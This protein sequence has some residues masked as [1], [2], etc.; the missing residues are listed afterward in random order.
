SS[1]NQ[2]S[3][4]YRGPGPGSEPESAAIM[5]YARSIFD[6]ARGPN[7]TDLAPADT[8]GVYIDIHSFS[9]LVIWPWG[10]TGTNA[11]NGNGMQTLGRRL[12]WFNGYRP[13]QAITLGFTDGTTDDFVYGDLGIAS[14]TYELGTSF[15]Q[16]CGTFENTIFPDNLP[17]LV[18]AAKA[19]RLPYLEPSGPDSVNVTL[20]PAAVGTG[21]PVTVSSVI[22]DTRFENRSG[23][24]PT[25][26]IVAAEYT[27]DTPPWDDAAVAVPMSAS[28][29]VFNATSEDASAVIDTTGLAQGRHTVY[30]RGQDATGQWGLV[31]A[32]FLFV[33]DPV[34]APRISGRVTAADTGEG[35]AA[36]VTAGTFTAN[37]DADGNY[38]L[39]VVAGEYDITVTPNDSAYG[40]QS[41][42]DVAAADTQTTTANFALFPFCALFSDDMETADVPWTTE[43]DWG[44]TD[45]Q[46]ASGSFSYTDSPGGAYGNNQEFSLILPPLDLSNV[47]V[48]NLEFA[49]RCVSEATYDFCI[50][51]VSPDGVNW[52]ELGRYDGIENTFSTRSFS[53]DAL[54]GSP[55]AQVRFRMS[56][57]VT[58]TRDG[59]YVDD[60]VLAGAGAQCVT[61][62]DTDGDGVNDLV[63]NCTLIANADQRDSNGDGFGNAC[64]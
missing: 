54:A 24:E 35:L 44:R 50:V 43:G 27:I 2:C 22:D 8:S 58:V 52:V 21:E 64:D 49:S 36:T 37:T 62:T 61:A 38:E 5:A 6:D 30:V 3:I 23:T 14:F 16:D 1:G 41:L 40:E 29:G 56:T 10:F 47:G 15:F 32:G 31:S 34:T 9:E 4:V 60:V 18:Y 11:P 63:D 26:N 12:A 28:D 53:T 19:A 55:N 45:A 48:V 39:L 25:Q 17:S 57:D 20:T 7:N 33:L 46:S 51:E 13:D 59:W 42:D